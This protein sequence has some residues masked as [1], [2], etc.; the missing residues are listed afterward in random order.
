M[1]IQ[2]L[3]RPAN[4]NPGHVAD[5]VQL[6]ELLNIIRCPLSPSQWRCNEAVLAVFMGCCYKVK[7]N[8]ILMNFTSADVP[9]LFGNRLCLG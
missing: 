9:D 7:L 4:S 8:L 3:A 5:V 6:H 1:E 2:F